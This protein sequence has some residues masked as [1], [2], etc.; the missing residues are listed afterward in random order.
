MFDT[1]IKLNVGNFKTDF[2]S[3]T[4]WI[5]SSCFTC[6][7]IRKKKWIKND[8]ISAQINLE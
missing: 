1:D 4:M 6:V 8:A 3:I 5:E 7:K 2:L